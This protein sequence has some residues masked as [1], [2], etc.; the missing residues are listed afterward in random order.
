M[1]KVLVKVG[2]TFDSEFRLACHCM[3]VAIVERKLEERCLLSGDFQTYVY[4]LSHDT[5]PAEWEGR[6]V[7]FITQDPTEFTRPNRYEFERTETK[8]VHHQG[9]PVLSFEPGESR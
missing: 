6:V 9:G 8:L 3:G 5:F 4:V 7:D 2:F 1:P